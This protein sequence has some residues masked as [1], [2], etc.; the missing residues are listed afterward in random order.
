MSGIKVTFSGLISFVIS[1]AVVLLGLIFTTIVTR[2]VNMHEYGTWGLISGLFGYAIVIEPLISYWATR[3]IARGVE[4][5]KTAILSSGVLSMGGTTVYILI[6][7]LVSYQTNVNQSILF[8]AAILIPLMFLNKTLVGINLGWKPQVISYGALFSG[9]IQIPTALIFVYFLHMGV[10]GIILTSV[11]GG[12]SSIITLTISARHKLK[13]GIKKELLRKWLKLFWLPLYPGLTSMI[14]SLDVVIFSIITKSVEGLAI[15]AVAR[16]VSN[17]VSQSNQ[18]SI[19]VYPKLL[20]GDKGEYVRENLTHTFY[21][22]IP[23]MALSITFAKPVLFTL[24]PIYEDAFPIVIFTTIFIFLTTLTGIFMSLLW[25]AEKVDLNNKSTFRDY[26]KS[27]LFFLPTLG[28]I[29]Y[30]VYVSLLVIGLL[31]LKP[32]ANSEFQLVT[33][34]SIIAVISHLPLTLY[35]YMLVRRNFTLKLNLGSI[36][37]YLLVSMGVFSITYLLTNQF[38]Q[39]KNNIFEFIPNLLPFMGLAIGGYVFFTYLT[40]SGTRKLLNTILS[41][42]KSNRT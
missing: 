34:W 2:S 21:F 20:S 1:L 27:K 25:A 32:L 38:L 18:I 3:E 29:Q 13:G 40:D 35:L 26:V 16:A 36:S 8:F 23:L 17:L 15:W 19:A 11:V 31:I 33:Y 7:Y 42:I 10:L 37:K 6:A 30:G 28:L 41:G 39:Y 12:I 24:N 14:F 5:G 9:L 22:A 4:S